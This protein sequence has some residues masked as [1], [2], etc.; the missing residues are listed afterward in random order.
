MWFK[1]SIY[2]STIKYI[3]LNLLC[4]SS[5]IVHLLPI[6]LANIMMTDKSVYK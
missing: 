1:I 2:L 6:G 3:F 5:D 4:C